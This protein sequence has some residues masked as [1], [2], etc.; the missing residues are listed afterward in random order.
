MRQ[1]EPTNRTGL[2]L[3]HHA[4]RMRENLEFEP[5]GDAAEFLRLH[6]SLSAAAPPIGSIPPPASVEAAAGEVTTGGRM[7]LLADKIGER[8]AFERAGTRLYDSLLLK[9]GTAGGFAGGPSVDDLLR[10]RDEEFWHV[11]ILTDALRRLDADPTAVTPS[12]DLGA[13][14]SSGVLAAIA[15]PRTTLAQSLEA[16]LVAELVDEDGWTRLIE[17]T[18]ALGQ[19]ELSSTFETCAATEATHLRAVHDWLAAGM[20][21]VVAPSSDDE[22]PAARSV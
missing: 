17:L 1:Q 11:Q 7:A 4:Q 9:H 3:S 14:A 5:E 22:E 6:A 12:A 15:D 20:R 18:R 10:H 21:A 2:L 13:V 19:S 8:L 16:M